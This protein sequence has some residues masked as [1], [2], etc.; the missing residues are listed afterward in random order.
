MM[1]K[2][3][4]EEF[5]AIFTGVL[6]I[7]IAVAW[8]SFGQ[9]AD[10]TFTCWALCQ[11]G[12]HVN[13]RMEPKKDS[14][15]VGFLECGDSFE[16]DGERTMQVNRMR[17]TLDCYTFTLVFQG[18][19]TLLHG[20]HRLTLH[21]GDMYIYM[22]GKRQYGWVEYRYNMYYAYKTSRY[23][24][25]KGSL[26][27]DVYRKHKGKI[28]YFG[29]D[30][31]MLTHDTKYIKLDKKR[32]NVRYIYTPG[33]PTRRYSVNDSHFQKYINKKWVNVGKRCFPHWMI[34]NQM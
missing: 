10:Q 12:D 32:F 25:P 11:P 29:I 16:T 15:S 8:L 34:D 23:G 22:Y 20:N 13:L 21:R 4:R 5:W 33:D 9:A 30:G 17:D 7:L 28:Y 26:A 14:K 3:N 19:L 31:K 18:E 1:Q 24:V 2:I 6:V 27:V